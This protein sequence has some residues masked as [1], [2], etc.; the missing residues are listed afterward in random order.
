MRRMTDGHETALAAGLYLVA[1]PIGA[2]RDIT[3]RALDVLTSADVLVAEDTRNLKKLCDIHGI[4]LGGR[5]LIAY[6]DHS[7]PGL[8]DK[9]A[10]MV[11]QGQSVAYASDAGTPLIADPGFA[12]AARIRETGGKVVA[13]PGPSALL[14]ALSVAGLPTDRFLFLGFLPPANAARTKTL[15]QISATPATLVFYETARRSPQM[16]TSCL[17]VLGD[18]PAALCRELTKKFEEV[19][20]GPL[21]QLIAGCKTD[22][23]RGEVVVLID[24]DRSEADP[25]MV[26]K[27][28]L[29]ALKT[30]SVKDA[31]RHV[32]DTLGIA[33]RDA[34][35]LALSLGE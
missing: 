15:Q 13:A 6:H 25:A 14:A 19:R 8:R 21:S 1:T 35:Q 2:A 16:L 5:P 27:A 7:G 11:A 18:R 28:L 22:P 9:L 24:R 3:L 12:L 30:M 10:A 33:R 34:Y 29:D 4:K 26:E 17:E 32:S 31:S 23:L 20:R